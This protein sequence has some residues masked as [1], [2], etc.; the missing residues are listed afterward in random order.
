M[1]SEKYMFIECV[2]GVNDC[3]IYKDKEKLMDGFY[4]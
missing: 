1:F 2:L 4:R 3:E